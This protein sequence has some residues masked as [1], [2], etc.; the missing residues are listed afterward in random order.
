MANPDIK[1]QID[2][3][4]AENS[5]AAQLTAVELINDIRELR[6]ICMGRKAAPRLVKEGGVVVERALKEFDQAGANSAL[7][8]LFKHLGLYEKDNEQKQSAVVQAIL[9]LPGDVQD[10]VLDGLYRIVES[11]QPPAPETKTVGKSST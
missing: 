5:K 11:D 8:K 9:Q 1:A 7:D 3:Q 6:D 4:L 2:Q 10:R